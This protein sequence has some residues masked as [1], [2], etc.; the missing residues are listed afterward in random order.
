[1]QMLSK[2]G[3]TISV[4]E[5]SDAIPLALFR[6]QLEF[7]YTGIVAI[8]DK[9][10]RVHETI[11]VANTF[12]C[13]HLTTY[14][15]NVLSGNV[16]LN[17]SI[18]TWLNDLLADKAKAHFFQKP[19]FSDVSFKV[20]DAEISAHKALLTTR[21][22]VI[23]PMWSGRFAES[24]GAPIAVG[25]TSLPTFQALIEYL[26]TAH[27]P[28]SSVDAAALLMLA[29]RFNV[30]R[31]VT[32]CELFLSK[33]VERETKDDIT[34]ADVDIIGMLIMAQRHNAK[35]LAQFCL[36]FISV[37]Y[38]PM[39]KRADFKTLERD[40]KS[41]VDEHQWPPLSYLK[42]VDKYEVEKAARDEKAG[43]KPKATVV[44]TR[45][46]G[47]S[48]FRKKD[49]K[50]ADKDVQ[51]GQEVLAPIDKKDEILV[52]GA[53]SADGEGVAKDEKCVIM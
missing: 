45:S 31:L 19:L 14:C 49:V 38:Q 44:G 7:W 42:E 2:H 12:G 51:H 25:D 20:E 18:G 15:N 53:A 11:E 17:P 16:E 22:D 26:Y 43:R 48:L 37:N 23:A 34:K 36:H 6:R 41:Y 46:T 50:N 13:E 3:K 4:I 5:V 30:S 9:N 10:D 35:Q 52:N 28:I 21:C 8:K 32:L 27:A 33:V 39:S 24:S 29:N 1:L 40:N 47:W